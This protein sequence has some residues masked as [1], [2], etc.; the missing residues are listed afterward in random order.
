RELVRDAES[1]SEQIHILQSPQ[2]L[3]V[4]AVTLGMVSNTSTAF[5]RLSDGA[6]LGAATAAR[7]SDRI[8]LGQD[9]TTLISN[10]LLVGSETVSPV[11]ADVAD[12]PGVA[13]VMGDSTSV[14]STGSD[15]PAVNT[16]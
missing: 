10:A 1:L 7:S 6:V 15:L 16:R 4:N 11:V 14:A 13:T 2:N 3:A 5:L 12:E 8:V 9:R